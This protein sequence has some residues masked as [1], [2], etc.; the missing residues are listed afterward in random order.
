MTDKCVFCLKDNEITREHVIP[1]QFFPSVPEDVIV[2][3]ACKQCN[4]SMGKIEEY[5]RTYLLMN[6]KCLSDTC[7]ELRAINDPFSN[8]LGR[9][10]GMVAVLKNTEQKVDEHTDSGLYVGKKTVVPIDDS[11]LTKFVTKLVK[12]LHF[13]RTKEYLDLDIQLG[14]K[15]HETK[16][17]INLDQAPHFKPQLPRWPKIFDWMV[18]PDLGDSKCFFTF[19]IWDTYAVVGTYGTPVSDEKS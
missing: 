3:A 13:H 6:T 15:W 12:G 1:R 19:I 10:P 2:V 9:S 7:K 4:G 18:N 11:K 14:Y 5:L 17:S 8:T 16:N